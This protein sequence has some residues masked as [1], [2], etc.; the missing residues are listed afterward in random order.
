MIGESLKLDVDWTENDLITPSHSL[1]PN[2]ILF[3]LYA[4]AQPFGISESDVLRSAQNDGFCY[5]SAF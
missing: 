5:L 1:E 4:A 3:F 2:L